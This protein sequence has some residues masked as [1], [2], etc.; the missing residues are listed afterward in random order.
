M[1][2][3]VFCD[4]INNEARRLYHMFPEKAKKPLTREQWRKHNRATTGHICFKEFK[5]DDIKVRDHC[6]YTR[7]Y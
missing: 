5:W 1:L 7:Q 6:H 2:I 3:G 4:H